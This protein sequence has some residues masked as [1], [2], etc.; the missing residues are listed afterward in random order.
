MATLTLSS[1]AQYKLAPGPAEAVGYLIYTADADSG[2][3]LDVSSLVGTIYFV[4][5]WDQDTGDIVTATE[6]SSDITIDTS[7]GTTNHN[8]G[9]LVF[10]LK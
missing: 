1:Q 9:I 10:G 3:T 2:D 8:Y 7:G 4:I 6:S 5:A